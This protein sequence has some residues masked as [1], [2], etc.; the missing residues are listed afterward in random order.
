[1][2]VWALAVAR[3]W[4][5]ENGW[6]LPADLVYGLEPV[7]DRRLV[8]ASAT[9]ARQDAS[10]WR[11]PAPQRDP[12][13]RVMRGKRREAWEEADAKTMGHKSDDG[14]PLLGLVSGPGS[15]AGGGARDKGHLVMVD[16]LRRKDPRLVRG[17]REFHAGAARERMCGR[18]DQ[19]ERIV[20]DGSLIKARIV[21][22]G[23]FRDGDHDCDVGLVSQ[24]QAEARAVLG[25]R[26]VHGEP[27]VGAAESGSGRSQQRCEPRGEP[28]QPQL[29]GFPAVGGG[30]VGAGAL[31]LGV[32]IIRMTQQQTCCRGQLHPAACG[33][34]EVDAELPGQLADLL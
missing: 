21:Q 26:Q 23:T 22:W 4:G 32:Q 31:P 25:L 9:Y 17:L 13:D 20:E 15:K 34:Q 6:K 12:H 5:H 11:G 27:R 18:D 3:A 30:Q 19:I 28:A 2:A 14:G 10:R 33:F 1:M 29:S 16:A 24:E 8:V 7:G